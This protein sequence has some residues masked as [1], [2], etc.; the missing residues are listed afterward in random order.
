[1]TLTEVFHNR[2]SKAENH[3]HRLSK[4]QAPTFPKYDLTAAGDCFLG[5]YAKQSMSGSV[6]IPG[7]AGTYIDMPITF[8]KNVTRSGWMCIYCAIGTAS[9]DNFSNDTNVPDSSWHQTGNSM[10]SRGSTNY[11]GSSAEYN[12][13]FRGEV[14]FKHLNA[15]DIHASD[16][17]DITYGLASSV[18]HTTDWAAVFLALFFDDTKLDMLGIPQ[19]YYDTHDYSIDSGGYGGSATSTD[20]TW[21]TDFGFLDSEPNNYALLAIAYSTPAIVFTPSGNMRIADSIIDTGV[22]IGMTIY[23][24]CLVPANTGMEPGGLFASATLQ[25]GAACRFTTIV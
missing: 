15:G 11:N 2:L 21:M 20:L 18:N 25:S 24:N 19:G 22:G 13:L 17:L 4:V 14:A 8:T 6:Y 9:S 3:A 7:F 10:L 16:T 12:D 1:M 5:T 23:K